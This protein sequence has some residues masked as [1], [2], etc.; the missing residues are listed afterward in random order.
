MKQKKG[1]VL[2][3]IFFILA[4][5]LMLITNVVMIVGAIG[6]IIIHGI[7][8]GVNI[9]RYERKK[10][11]TR[12]KVLLVMNII[13]IVYF[14][15]MIVLY[16]FGGVT[17]TMY[18]INKHE[19]SEDLDNDGKIDQIKIKEGRFTNKFHYNASNLMVD[20]NTTDSTSNC[21]IYVND[22]KIGELQVK[23][24]SIIKVEKR[25]NKNVLMVSSIKHEW[26]NQ[27]YDIDYYEFNGGKL[28]L[29]EKIERIPYGVYVLM[30]KMHDYSNATA[31]YI[32]ELLI[33]LKYRLSMDPRSLS[34][35]CLQ[36]NTSKNRE[37]ISIN[38]TDID[39]TEDFKGMIE[40]VRNDLDK[41]IE[42][43]TKY[44]IEFEIDGDFT[45]IRCSVRD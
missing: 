15:R 38:G 44:D 31:G 37:Y 35:I 36:Y 45:T 43:K 33:S 21:K 41:D 10:Q 27:Y 42:N 32:S 12:V 19:F 34:K 4:V 6:S 18:W 24:L 14:V 9:K 1:I 23:D 20:G 7:W 26:I 39:E 8:L 40:K 28:N 30:Y 17:T 11:R 13:A 16:N 22:K 3:I 29:V 5:I 25:K 2:D